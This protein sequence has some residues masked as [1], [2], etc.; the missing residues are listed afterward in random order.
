MSSGWEATL[1]EHLRTAAAMRDQAAVLDAI[2]DAIV[3]AIRNGKRVY[4]LGNG[5]SA[6]D[7]QHIAAE[8]LGRFR[9]D[10]AALPAM[11]L[12]T[13]SSVLTAISNDLGYE[14]AF[15]RQL[16]GLLQP[17]DVVWALSTSGDSPN[18]LQ[19][20]RLAAARGAVTIGFSG[21]AGHRLAECCAHKLL[22][23]HEA[24]DRIQECHQIAYHYVCGRVEEA[25]AGK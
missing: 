5:G 23:P 11:A 13:D 2:A 1:Q 25:F 15:S 16:E 19:A 9:T 12:T 18:V 14:R 4:L 10:R 3:A 8:L 22:V 7:A 24:S 20:V 17:G 21:A 6:A